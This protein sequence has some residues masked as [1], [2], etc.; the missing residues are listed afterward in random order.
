MHDDD[1]GGGEDVFVDDDDDDDDGDDDGGVPPDIRE[2]ARGQGFLV[3]TKVQLIKNLTAI[4][5]GSMTMLLMVNMLLEGFDDYLEGSR[6]NVRIQD[7]HRLA[8]EFAKAGKESLQQQ[9][10]K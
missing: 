2:L 7:L 10:R 8:A 9:R 6:T 3:G 5:A 4:Q 1:D